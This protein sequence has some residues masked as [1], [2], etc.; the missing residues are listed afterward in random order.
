M[1][2]DD[3]CEHIADVIPRVMAGI[4][5]E[6]G[7]PK[8]GADMMIL[9]THY[10]VKEA[11]VYP[12]PCSRTPDRTIEIFPDDV[13]TGKNGCYTK[14]TGLCCFNIRIPDA[15]VVLVKKPIK[16]LW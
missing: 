8:A 12:W 10:K 15:D 3:N 2:Y 11:K 14:H 5:I 7:Q 6:Y 4:G 16:L 9:R 1:T 13:L